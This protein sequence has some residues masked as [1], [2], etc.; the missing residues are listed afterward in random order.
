MKRRDTLVRLRRAAGI[1]LA[2]L[3][4]M[5]SPALAQV[6]RA[7]DP[8]A[9]PERRAADAAF[10]RGEYEEAG[11]RYEQLA[12]EDPEDWQAAFRAAL[13]WHRSGDYERSAA[14]HKRV[15]RFPDVAPTAFYNLACALAQLG[16]REEALDALEGA[17][18]AGFSDLETIRRDSDLESIS[19]QPR[20]ESI[21]TEADAPELRWDA[22]D[23]RLDREESQ[24][25][26]GVVLV[27]RNGEIVHHEGYGLAD[28]ESGTPVGPE[29]VFSIGSIPIDFTHVAILQLLERGELS[30]EDPV[31]RYFPEVP[32][33]KQAMTIGH[34]LE[35]RSGL[36]D[37]HDRPG[38]A[39][40]DLSWIDRDE[41]VRRILGERLLFAPG[42]STQHSHSAW[43]LLAAVV[44]IVSA[45][46]Y[47]DYLREHILEPAGMTDTG[48]NGDPI[49][50]DRV[51]YGYGGRS[52]GERNAPPHWGRTSWL[53]LGSGGQVSTAMDLYRFQ[54]ALRDGKLLGEEGLRN[55]YGTTDGEGIATA[56]NVRGFWCAYSQGAWSKFIVLS[57]N[58]SGVNLQRKAKLNRL[59]RDLYSL[60]DPIDDGS[61]PPEGEE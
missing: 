12:A 18:D 42:T 43:G 11:R 52:A 35:S 37:F 33:D 15:T 54:R 25:F 21:L 49:A 19:D 26:S 13:S 30:R 4:L 44:E 39:D 31:S 20:F 16:R 24:G 6:E 7:G 50:T 40:P 46:S 47:A 9:S 53:I 51:A 1:G 55:Y 56:G 60:V 38:D 17:I 58:S 22:L 14:A 27:E 29:T 36:P 41:A 28:R 61:S 8:R 23:A 3:T 2:I 32:A 48:F 45:Q 10:Q 57:N 59:A 5:T 34:L